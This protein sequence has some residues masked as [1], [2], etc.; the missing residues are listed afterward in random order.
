MP[1]DETPNLIE[2]FEKKMAALSKNIEVLVSSAR[3][4]QMLRNLRIQHFV[5]LGKCRSVELGRKRMIKYYQLYSS[6]MGRN[7]DPVMEEFKDFLIS[8]KSALD[9]LAQEINIVF[10]IKEPKATFNLKSFVEKLQ[11]EDAQFASDITKFCEKDNWFTY[12]LKLRNPSTHTG[13]ITPISY[14]ELKM[15]RDMK[16]KAV[17]RKIE[18]EIQ[19]VSEKDLVEKPLA[20]KDDC[21]RDV[22]IYLPDNPEESDSS[23]TTC[24]RK[25]KFKD[26]H[27]DLSK[28]INFLFEKCYQKVDN[29]LDQMKNPIS[30]K[31]C[32][33]VKCIQR[34]CRLRLKFSPQTQT[35]RHR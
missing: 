6:S 16:V 19:D 11:K 31:T 33:K 14:I 34:N 7:L 13:Q 30:N 23:K 8:A 24:D 20:T 5:T 4:C 18:G 22:G 26:Y 15:L 3:N 12:F 21:V 35:F 17:F 2:L 28:R 27:V 1:E 32:H 9:S 10:C 29:E 25:I